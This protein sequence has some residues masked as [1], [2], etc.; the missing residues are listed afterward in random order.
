MADETPSPPIRLVAPG[1]P[2]PEAAPLAVSSDVL[3]MMLRM[4][5]AI[6]MLLQMPAVKGSPAAQEMKAEVLDMERQIAVLLRTA[7]ELAERQ[8]GC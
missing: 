5:G 6:R 7:D 2:E 3:A 1:K 8:R 4:I